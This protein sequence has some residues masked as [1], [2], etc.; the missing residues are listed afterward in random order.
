MKTGFAIALVQ[1]LRVKFIFGGAL[2]FLAGLLFAL[3]LGAP[4]DPSKFLLGYLIFLFGH[5]SVSFTNDHFDL[6]L[7]RLAHRT[8]FSGGGGALLHAREL[9]SLVVPLAILFSISSVLLAIL[10]KQMYGYP[11]WFP[12]FVIMG[13][14]VGWVYSAPPIRLSRRGL[15]E[16]LTAAGA[17]IFMPGMGY[18]VA[19]GTFDIPFLLLSLPLIAYGVLFILSVEIPDRE[20]DLLGGK[21]TLVVRCGRRACIRAIAVSAILATVLFIAFAILEI[22]PDSLNWWVVA[23][24]SLLPLASAILG[25]LR[26]NYFR[27]D[28][29]PGAIR[30]LYALIAFLVLTDLHLFLSILS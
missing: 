24:A 25:F 9:R 17:G 16:P 20:A 1:Q 18:L 11:L 19:T 28:S 22:S 15:G 6:A 10:F 2:F 4:S 8:P 12:L 23:G 3:T 5:V 26:G 30:N 29:I 14:L 7:D 13:N 27:R 21:R